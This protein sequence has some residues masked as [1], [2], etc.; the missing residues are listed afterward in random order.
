MKSVASV[1]STLLL[2]ASSA[3]AA[4]LI[5]STTPLVNDSGV[6]EAASCDVVGSSTIFP[7][8]GEA[9]YHFEGKCTR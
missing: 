7:K 8:G 9:T 3:Q 4:V 6:G 1:A 2:A 5:V